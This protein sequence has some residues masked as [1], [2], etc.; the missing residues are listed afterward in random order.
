MDYDLARQVSGRVE[1]NIDQATPYGD[2]PNSMLA[3]RFEETDMGPDEGLYNHFVRGEI[4][5]WGPDTN[6]ME[7]ERPRGRVNA[8]AG[9]IQL[10]HEGH[11]G[12]AEVDNPE[13]FLGFSGPEDWDPRGIKTDP[14]MKEY[15]AQH[16]ARMRFHRFT[17]D[18]SEHVTG[19]GRS[20][21]QAI[22]DQQKIFKFTRS[23]LK[24]FNRQIDGRREG[25]RR[26]YKHKSEIAKQVLVQSYGDYL[27]DYAMNPQRRA[28]L[29]S[30]RVI[31]D[32]R[33]W[34]DGT[35]DQDYQFARYTQICRKRLTRETYS[36][37]LGAQQ[38]DEA[39][40][41]DGDASKC[42]RAAG[43]LMSHMVRNKRQAHMNMNKSDIDMAKTK[44]TQD[45]KTAPVA[46]DLALVLR[47]I[48]SDGKFSEGDA[49]M[50]VKSAHPQMQEHQARQIVANH[51]TPAHHYLNAEILYKTVK[52]NADL[53]KIK[54]QVITDARTVDI[55]DG[56]TLVGKSA[57]R[58]MV[59]GRNLKT[60]E[61]GDKTESEQTINYRTA[62]G[63]NKR[64]VGTITS[65]EDYKKE[66]DNSQVRTQSHAEYR[67]A[68]AADQ[69]TQSDFLDN[70]QSER[71]GGAMGSK[72]M[73]RFI[74]R[75][76]KQSDINT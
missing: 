51:S 36:K 1:Y 40:W 73:N 55:Q 65:G 19:G 2:M 50:T 67:V 6:L 64:H 5:D 46:R 62:L 37:V 12:T 68:S 34:R 39:A 66:S 52:P 23:H 59:T 43:I 11:R 60:T 30:G 26:V 28:N 8:S 32:S 4:K 41:N 48:A 70:S 56:D 35:A 69:D 49:T 24:V 76:G 33:S 27:K 16:Q 22:A 47:S 13:A 45:R 29:I 42:Y 75:D 57:K 74:D 9:M 44:L 15:T 38:S 53:R 25:L 3:S 14:D 54:D 61:D 21:S 18:H 72:Y 71:L 58:H 7:H 63:H 31:R 20:E 10:R 17:P